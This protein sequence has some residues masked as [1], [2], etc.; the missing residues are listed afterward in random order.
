VGAVVCLVAGLSS[1]GVP[2]RGNATPARSVPEGGA[3]IAG[4]YTN[5]YFGLT[6]PLMRGWSAG[7]AG[8]PPS[9]AG[10]YVLINLIPD[11]EI[12]ATIMITAQDMFFAEKPLDAAATA[13]DFRRTV[14]EIVGMAIDCEPEEI[15]IAGRTFYR[16]EFSGVGLYRAML[17]TEDHCHLVQFHLTAR[18]PGILA[19]LLLSLDNLSFDVKSSGSTPPPVC[20]KDYAIADTVLRKVAPLPVEP[21]FTPIPV[22][23]VISD[24]GSVEQVHVI[25]AT[26]D[27]RTVIENALYQWK[28]KPYVMDGRSVEVETGLLFQFTAR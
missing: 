12:T 10:E 6:Y 14:S 15:G 21:A 5:E 9:Q 3:V 1:Y 16:V 23:I 18:E 25:R 2:L 13:K 19:G 20:T 26:A 11:G 17:V 24:D 22:R 4:V 8:P 28:F 27:Q 7:M